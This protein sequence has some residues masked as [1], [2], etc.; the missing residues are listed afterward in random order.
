MFEFGGLNLLTNKK[1]R[2]QSKQI[3]LTVGA[4]RPIDVHMQFPDAEC[5]RQRNVAPK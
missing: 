3:K 4:Y 5:S 1:V 2:C